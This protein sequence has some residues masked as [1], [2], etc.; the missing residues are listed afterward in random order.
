[1]DLLEYGINQSRPFKIVIENKIDIFFHVFKKKGKE[2]I[3][4]MFR[5][6]CYAVRN[7]YQAY[8][9]NSHGDGNILGRWN[10]KKCDSSLNNYLANIDSCGDRVCGEIT[11]VQKDVRQITK[12]KSK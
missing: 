11:L 12:Q 8:K 10:W 6:F 5:H 2:N 9:E 4:G 7:F 3:F 1:M